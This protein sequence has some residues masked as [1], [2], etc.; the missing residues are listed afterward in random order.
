[1][2][3]RQGVS[4][5]LGLR[6][7]LL[8]K[9]GNMV[10]NQEVGCGSYPGTGLAEK[11][12]DQNSHTGLSFSSILEIG[13]DTGTLSTQLALATPKPKDLVG[14]VVTPSGRMHSWSTIPNR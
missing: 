11:F 8:H 13:A 12:Q 2:D 3:W 1:M 10:M 4:V 6:F 14:G 7:R 9:A 5:T